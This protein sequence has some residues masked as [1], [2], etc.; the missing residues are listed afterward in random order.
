M[1]SGFSLKNLQ[2]ILDDQ[3]RTILED[4]ERLMPLEVKKWMDWDQTKDNEGSW[5]KTNMV[6]LWFKHDT[7]FMLMNVKVM[8][9]ELD[10]TN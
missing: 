2:E 4:L 1:E 7:G 6:S 9:A 3:L 8:R 10:K 5:P